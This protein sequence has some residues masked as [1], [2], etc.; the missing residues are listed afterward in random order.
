M[1][2]L[3]RLPKPGI[4]EEK[5]ETWRESFVNS[6][7]K[8]PD[9]NKYAHLQIRNTLNSMSFYKCFYCE[10]KLKGV[11][12]EIDHFIEVA[13]RRDLAYDWEN[14]YLACDNCNNKL[15]NRSIS[16]TEVLDPCRD[17]DED[18]QEHLTFEDEIIRGKNGSEK[19]LA[20]IQKYRLGSEQLDM[21]RLKEIKNFHKLLI[22]IQKNIYNEK[23]SINQIEKEAL[24]SFK[25]PDRPFS[26]MFK[27]LLEKHPHVIS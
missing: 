4:L 24:L 3:H 19:G 16:V 9:N 17:K 13:E 25:N 8:R 6:D 12:Q 23:R 26:L 27:V 11:A 10:R 1:R 21:A 22:L 14:L 20:T 15:P 2:S 7:K 18:I 5:E